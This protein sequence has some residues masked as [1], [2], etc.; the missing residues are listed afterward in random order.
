[1]PRAIWSGAISF[2]LVNVPVK[3]YSAVNRKTVRFNQLEGKTG[4]RV[5][6]KRVSAKTGEEVPFEEIVKGYEI[7]K[8][9]YVVVKPEELEALDPKKTRTIEIVE[10][11][12]QDQI[13]PIFYDHPYYLVPDRGADKAYNLLL[14]AMREAGKVAIARVVIRSKE[15]LTAIR[16]M[17]GVLAMTTMLFA[18]EIVPPEKLDE[19]PDSDQ[20]ASAREVKMAQQLIG[21]LAADFEPDKFHDEYRESVME[22]IER[23]AQG[24]EITIQ[25]QEEVTQEAPDLMAALEA[26]VAA[27]K[28][29]A[30]D[31]GKPA[32]AAARKRA[33]ASKDGG[34]KTA[35]RK[36]SSAKSK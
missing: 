15:S 13:D 36:R 4:A 23:K 31:D 35:A 18:D 24:E 26:S 12:D 19:L 30:T 10:F 27:A 1:M 8:D 5:Q 34:A 20:E 17:E 14:E 21:S 22:L 33:P 25:E 29:R 6:Q 28:D 7:S 9:R 11:V 16:P 2:G 32:K 3:V